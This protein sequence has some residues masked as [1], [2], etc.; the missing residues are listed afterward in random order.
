MVSIHSS[1]AEPH[2]A[3]DQLL[4]STLAASAYS[5]LQPT[6][7]LHAATLVLAK[8][9]LD[10]LAL[11]ATEAQAERL[12]ALRRKR[13][14]G[15]S[16]QNTF[17][18][19]FHLRQVHLEGLRTPQVWEQARRVLDASTEE[20]ESSLQSVLPTAAGDVSAGD[21]DLHFGNGSQK[22]SVK[23]SDDH[24]DQ[25]KQVENG[26]DDTAMSEDVDDEAPSDVDMEEEDSEAGIEAP[27]G[28]EESIDEMDGEE[29][30]LGASSHATSDM[31]ADSPDTFVPDK[32]G[33]NDGFFSIDDFNKQS[34]FLEYQD[35]RGEPDNEASDEE[36]IDWASEPQPLLEDD[37]LNGEDEDD[38]GGDD[39]GPT[40]GNADLN[41]E[42]TD[43]DA[44]S[45]LMP[46]ENMGPS[47]NT[48]DI[49]YADFFAP[50]PRKATKSTRMRALPKTQ[51]APSAPEQEDDINRTIA[52]V[53]RDIFEDDLSA[54][55]DSAAD[56]GT[57]PNDPRSSHRSNHERRQAKIVAEIRK[58]EAA[59]VAKRD[60]TLSGE[61]RAADRPMNSLLEED[62]EFER[63]GKPVPVITNEV[64]EDIEALIKRRI[65]SREFDEVIRRRPGSLASSS[66][67]RR[68][69]F[70]LDD[71]K[72]QQS[73]AEIYEAEHLKQVD[74][75]GYIEK[76]DAKLKKEHEAIEAM[77]ADIS[78]S[79][80]TLS[81]WHYKPKPPEAN[82]TV[83]SDVP[84]ISMEDARPAG[85]EG[86]MMGMETSMLAPQEIYKPGEERSRV[87]RAREVV[88]SK[89]GAPVARE[90]MTREQK[91]RRRRREKER[92]RKQGGGGSNVV[93]GGA[94]KEATT[95]GAGRRKKAERNGVVGDLK[96]GGVIV[97]GK[98]GELVD[99]EGKA[100]KGATTSTGGGGG[101]FKL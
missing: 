46:M 67:A 58:L 4:S 92:I 100:V 20:L 68:G 98:K 89:S 1:I 61:A 36:E 94:P 23:F 31:D 76:R 14:R 6:S 32:H 49:M 55:G 40:F 7:A 64:S 28:F 30:D 54:S 43:S 17:K 50:P 42:D 39:K 2:P 101:N 18:R 60:W 84:K 25:S 11:S 15:Q 72:P 57:N 79:L 70:E 5:F 24:N 63:A 66:T 44:S 34:D 90:E 21:E 77:W 62:L 48:N 45:D 12:Q 75:T 41:A 97:I 85:S 35:A 96:K 65:I 52:A 22:K 71:T 59:N 95:N 69:R 13:K 10:P 81:N 47:S 91:L 99:V 56:P 74:P 86:G 53:R 93:V 8:R 73:L 87:D 51:P 3:S 83:V 27:D 29:D 9:Y 16:D 37:E 88:L 38:L 19:P 33:L 26:M 82:I 78:N 80:D